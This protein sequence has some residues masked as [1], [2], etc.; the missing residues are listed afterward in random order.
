[1]YFGY[2]H[3]IG[4]VSFWYTQL[5]I[6]M[7]EYW[8]GYRERMCVCVQRMGMFWNEQWIEYRVKTIDFMHN[9]C[10][11]ALVNVRRT[12][13]VFACPFAYPYPYPYP[14]IVS[15]VG[16]T[17]FLFSSFFF[18]IFIVY[19]QITEK[20]RFTLKWRYIEKKKKSNSSIQSLE[21]NHKVSLNRYH[22]PLF[23][24]VLAVVVVII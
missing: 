16:S 11:C 23:G 21:N 6:Y 14:Y 15:F 7:G 9:L 5:L 1:M 8:N 12:S 2:L 19:I 24:N 3:A 20:A 4:Q 10:A 13:I 18:H 17:S 22:W